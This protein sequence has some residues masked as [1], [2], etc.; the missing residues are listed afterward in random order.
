MNKSIL[1]EVAN[2]YNFND[3]TI[4]EVRS[5]RVGICDEN[6]DGKIYIKIE[7]IEGYD[8]NE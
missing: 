3:N 7:N 5:K 8:D 6:Y 1:D 2:Y 4:S